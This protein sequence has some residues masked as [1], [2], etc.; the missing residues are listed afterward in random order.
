M[1]VGQ[2]FDVHAFDPQ[3]PLILG[4]VHVPDAPGLAG[5][6]DADVLCHA[7]ADALLG[8]ASLGDIGT[9]FPAVDRWKD[10]SS[11]EILS[12]TARTV[13]GAGWEIANV[14]GTLVA[15]Q[16][17]LSPFVGEMIRNVAEALAVTASQVSVKATTTD[18]LGFVGREEGI[19]GLAVALIERS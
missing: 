18:H 14:D 9:L 17:R 13:K 10:A 12:E 5:H 7:L 16:P 8:A 1:R 3:R 4:G 2:G 6:S 11:L 19:A 15:Q